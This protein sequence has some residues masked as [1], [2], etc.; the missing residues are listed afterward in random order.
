MCM[1]LFF[2]FINYFT[3]YN[4][5]IVKVLVEKRDSLANEKKISPITNNNQGLLLFSN[6]LFQ[7]VTFSLFNIYFI[8]CAATSFLLILNICIYSLI[9]YRVIVSFCFKFKYYINSF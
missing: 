5:N 3:G 4:D 2:Y 6:D 7:F 1:A 9:F 8:L